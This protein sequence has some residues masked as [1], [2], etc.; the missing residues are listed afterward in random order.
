MGWI[1]PTDHTFP[2]SDVD[3]G[4]PEW[5]SKNVKRFIKHDFKEK[6]KK[7][8]LFILEKNKGIR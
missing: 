1:W 8:G 5:N 2:T 3:K 7:L 6:E 4:S